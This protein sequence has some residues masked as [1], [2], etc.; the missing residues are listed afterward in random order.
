MLYRLL[1]IDDEPEILEWLELLLRTSLPYETEVYTAHGAT[2]ALEVLDRIRIDLVVSDIN[3]PRMSGLELSKKIHERWKQCRII[4]LSGYD[5]FEYIYQA[6][7]IPHARYVLKNEDDAVLLREIE[8]AIDEIEESRRQMEELNKPKDTYFLA[9]LQQEYLRRLINREYTDYRQLRNDMKR[10]QIALDVERPIYVLAGSIHMTEGLDARVRM[11]YIYQLD[12]LLQEELGDSMT[13]ALYIHDSST[14]VW[15][16]QDHNTAGRHIDMWLKGI[17]ENLQ[18]T[19]RTVWRADISFML[20]D[21]PCEINALAEA[22]YGVTRQLSQKSVAFKEVLLTEEKP[23][24]GRSM[25]SS[26]AISMKLKKVSAFESELERGNT[27]QCRALLQDITGVLKSGISMHDMSAVEMYL[28]LAGVLVR[29]INRFERMPELAFTVGVA[30][31]ANPGLFRT[32]E[33]AVQYLWSVTTAIIDLDDGRKKA[34]QT[35]V[36]S[37]VK[38]YIEKHMHEDISLTQIATEVGL[39]PSY[40]SR[41]Y[42]AETGDNISTVIL[43]MKMEQAQKLL[44]KRRVKVQEVS[45]ALGYNT[46]SY[47]AHL[48]KKVTGLTPNEFH[49]QAAGPS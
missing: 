45:E 5:R 22:L 10:L 19:G 8:Q 16:I 26:L 3:M 2:E 29:H 21:S 48:F 9:F 20:R 31:L 6:Q 35:D 43:N 47:F 33:E 24:E 46:P 23:E 14:A 1:I 11:E 15:L 36:V 37:T 34:A 28:A 49:D 41:L 44:S 4:F 42:K 39:N 7:E 12:R 25:S 38:G 30:G 13:A 32:W 40:L 17:L 27:E 18:E